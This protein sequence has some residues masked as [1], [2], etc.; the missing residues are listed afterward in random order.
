MLQDGIFSF[1]SNQQQIEKLTKAN[2][3]FCKKSNKSF[4]EIDEI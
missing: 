3:E 2:Q 4:K 1:S